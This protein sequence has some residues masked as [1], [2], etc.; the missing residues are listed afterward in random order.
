M[1]ARLL[2][3]V[4]GLWIADSSALIAFRAVEQ[5]LVWNHFL[6]VQMWI[7]VL[8]LIDVTADE[9]NAL[10]GGGV[11]RQIFFTWSP[12]T[13]KASR[14]QRLRALGEIGQLAR[15]HDPAALRDPASPA[16]ASLFRLLARL[17][18]RPPDPKS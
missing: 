1:A 3:A 2:E 11:L 5:R 13:L 16:N 17:A 9:P 6:A 8:F 7:V 15:A 18:P 14:H 10:I 12:A 4:I